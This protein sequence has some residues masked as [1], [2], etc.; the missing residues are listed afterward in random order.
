MIVTFLVEGEPQGKARHRTTKTGHTYT[1]QKTV[2]YENL[3]KTCY[4]S[5]V[6]EKVLQGPL[7]ATIE[8]YYTIPKSKSKKIKEQM[9]KNM[10]R[11]TKKPDSDN[12]AKA[13]LDS[14]N[15]IAYKDDAQVVDLSVSKYYADEGFVKIR[16]E[17]L[18][19]EA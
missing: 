3:I 14:I 1:P 18:E 13:V 5:R 15:G 2:L 19:P 8:A 4:L 12:V 16:L 10:I 11:P 17:E 7:K 6:G 9:R